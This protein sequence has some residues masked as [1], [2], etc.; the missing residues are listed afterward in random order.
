MVGFD[1]PAFVFAQDPVPWRQTTAVEGIIYHCRNRSE[2]VMTGIISS[3]S[4]V[5]IK[6]A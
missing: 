1:Q 5:N 2:T 6:T 4:T 3:L